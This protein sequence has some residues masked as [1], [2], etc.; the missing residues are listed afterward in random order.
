MRSGIDEVRRK[1]MDIDVDPESLLNIPLIKQAFC[2]LNFQFVKRGV[3][4]TWSYE[5]VIP[6]TITGFNPFQNS[7]YYGHS[8]CF[9][10]WLESPFSSAR[11]LNENDLLVREALLMAHDYLH[12]WAYQKIDQLLPQLGVLSGRITAENFEDYTFCHLVTEAVATVGLDYWLLSVKGLNDYC[13]IGS[14]TT[15]L[16]VNYR[17][18]LMAEYRKFYPKLEVQRPEFLKEMATFYCTGE[19][20][21]F[22]VYDLKR[23]PQLHLW[24]QHEL[25]YG[26]TQRRLTRMW[27]AY[28]ASEGFELSDDALDSP[29]ET[30]GE[31]K[32]NLLSDLSYLLWKKVKGNG[33]EKIEVDEFGS[34]KPAGDGRVASPGK[35]PDFRFV[36]LGRIPKGEWGRAADIGGKENFRYFVYQYLSGIPFSSAPAELIKLAP[37]LI[38]QRDVELVETLVGDLPRLDTLPGE[39]KDIFLPN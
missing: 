14:N 34:W 26:V 27:L 23:S 15:I 31:W 18:S 30:E 36:N 21:G 39:P 20:I 16:T 4:S 8:S 3:D 38:Q 7:F 35:S 19:F 25:S 37:I 1:A 28:L 13:P 6:I 32:Q 5:K 29:V 17:E 11:D 2:D 22:D 24:L 33:N 10:A 9:A 12:A